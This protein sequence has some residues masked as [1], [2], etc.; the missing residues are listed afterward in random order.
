MTDG[1]SE[2]PHFQMRRPVEA[3]RATIAELMRISFPIPASMAARIEE[4]IDL[5]RV[6]AAYDFDGRLLAMA[7]AHRLAQWYGGRA[8]PCAGIA[9]VATVPEAR[10]TGVATGLL[11]SL[12]REQRSAGALL[13]TLYP[14]TVPVYRR[15]GYEYAGQYTTYS[16]A[17]RALPATGGAPGTVE[18]LSLEHIDEILACYRAYAATQNGLV[19]SDSEIWWRNRVMRL[20]NSDTMPRVVGVR[21]QGR[22][23]GYAAFTRQD[24][25]GSGFNLECTHLVSLSKT[26]LESLLGYFRRFQGVGRELLYRGAALDPVSLAIP[27]RTVKVDSTFPTMSRLLDVKAGLEARGYANVEGETTLDVHDGLI[28]EN[29]GRFR[30]HASN[31]RVE[32]ERKSTTSSPD[33]SVGIGPLTAMF[34]G[35]LSPRDAVR[36]GFLA[37]GETAK[38]LERLFAGSPPWTT[39]FF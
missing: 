32:V 8:V 13:S 9:S 21:G 17:L 6:L 22:L 23:E 29:N 19:D 39:D 24:V 1:P 18:R 3:D 4:F 20:W 5:D 12:L 36:L 10:G 38:F 37:E 27:E 35:F 14:A 25:P 2:E 15:L 33:E 30:I 7:Q 26:A 11:R 34:T 28:D 31:G 16:V